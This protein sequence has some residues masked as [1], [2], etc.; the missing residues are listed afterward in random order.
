ME[1]LKT[2]PEHA[3]AHPARTNV[4]NR[5]WGP[6]LA[7]IT[8]YAAPEVGATYNRILELCRQ[9]GDNGS[10]F[11]ALFGLW[12]F[13]LVRPDIHKAQELAEQMM[14]LAQ[15]SHDPALLLEAHRALGVTLFWL[16]EL[17]QGQRHVE[18]GI[19]LYDIHKHRAHAFRYGIDPGVFCLCVAGWNLWCLGY[20]E[21]AL[22]S[23]RDALHLAHELAHPYTLAFALNSY[24]LI[25]ISFVTKR[26][27]CENGQKPRSRFR[28]S[29]GLPIGRRGRL[30]YRAGRWR[31]RATWK[32]D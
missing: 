22:K 9:V 29:T 30:S 6:P 25:S 13:Y 17:R 4:A 27:P 10:L 28:P 3:R 8:G 19:A 18:Q 7:A 5:P 2:L 14:R 26:Q 32:K 12:R 21:Q 20:P 11:P 31:H 24:C 15:S 23:T 16:G 1:L